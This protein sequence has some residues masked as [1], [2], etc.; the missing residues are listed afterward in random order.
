MLEESKDVTEYEAWHNLAN[1]VV[2]QACKDYRKAVANRNY[3][4]IA[5]IERFLRSDWCYTL[6]N[7]DAEYLIETLRK[8]TGYYGR[9]KAILKKN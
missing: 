6:T 5:S 9:K 4:E 1:A 8:E 3:G 7:V 2:L